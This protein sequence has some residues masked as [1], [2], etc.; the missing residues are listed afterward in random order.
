MHNLKKGTY[1]YGFIT[2]ERVES[3]Q[4]VL[5]IKKFKYK[6]KKMAVKKIKKN[7]SFFGD[8]FCPLHPGKFTNPHNLY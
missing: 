8:I 7:S 4:K 2:F 1:R 5:K 3:A 6:N